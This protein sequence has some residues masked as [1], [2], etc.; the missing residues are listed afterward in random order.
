MK[1]AFYGPDVEQGIIREVNNN[2]YIMGDSDTFYQRIQ[3]TPT[4]VGVS[5]DSD[6]GFQTVYLDSAYD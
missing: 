1:I 4:P 2:L 5:P 6:Y 3:T